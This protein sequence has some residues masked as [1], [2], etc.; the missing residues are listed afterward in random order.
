MVKGITLDDI[1]KQINEDMQEQ[2]QENLEMIAD[3]LEPPH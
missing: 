2:D 3:L 1:I